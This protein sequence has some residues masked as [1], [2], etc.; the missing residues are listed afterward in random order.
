MTD[1]LRPLKT[2]AIVSSML[3]AIF[4]AQIQ[5]NYVMV[6]IL[7]IAPLVLMF[8][9]RV[10]I[11]GGCAVA[12]YFSFLTLP[13]MPVDLMLYQ[14]FMLL[15]ILSGLAQRIIRKQAFSRPPGYFWCISLILLIFVIIATR[16]F[17]LRILGG[18]KI[19]GA[20]YVHVLIAIGFFLFSGALCLSPKQWKVFLLCMSLFAVYPVLVNLFIVLTGGR[21]TFLLCF[22]KVTFAL[23]LTFSNFLQG[24]TAIRWAIVGN[25]QY[26]YFLPILLF[27]SERKYAFF[28]VLFFAISIIA[29]ALSGTRL[30]LLQAMIFI[31]TFIVYSSK[32]RKLTI[33]LLIISFVAGLFLLGVFAEY[34]PFSMQRAISFIPGAHID[35]MAKL[36][37]QETIGWRA[38]LWTLALHEI[39]K[40]LLI[41]QGFAFDPALLE[42][43]VFMYSMSDQ[44]FGAFSTGDLHLGPLSIVYTYGIPGAILVVGLSITGFIWHYKKHRRRWNNSFLKRAHLMLLI[45]LFTNIATYLI[46][47]SARY[48]IPALFFQFAVLY[49]IAVSDD[50]C[51][52]E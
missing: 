51:C 33:V 49:S 1:Y 21:S 19:G 32:S 26:L 40:Y 13:A 27:P 12:T 16:G 47:G 46:S 4:Y 5:N 45:F 28:Y 6:A 17:G 38:L 15:L 25:L 48:I 20:A 35:P 42:G 2:V 3:I 11:I 8:I 24:D 7:A 14:V 37:A 22:T 30:W 39:P 43:P 18:N 41:G 34:L 10:S 31:V 50:H 29:V 36:D 52:S 9:P 23:Q 44:I